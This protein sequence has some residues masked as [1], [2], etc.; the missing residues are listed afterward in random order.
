MPLLAVG[1]AGAVKREDLDTY[2]QLRRKEV[3]SRLQSALENHAPARVWLETLTMD[4][5]RERKQN[6]SSVFAGEPLGEAEAADA[7]QQLKPTNDAANLVEASETL[8][9]AFCGFGVMQPYGAVGIV[10]ALHFQFEVN[11]ERLLAADLAPPSTSDRAL[12]A[13]ARTLFDD[14]EAA[15]AEL[16]LRCV[17]DAGE[18][19]L[20]ANP[21][22]PGM[23]MG[24]LAKL[25]LFAQFVLVLNNAVEATWY[26]EA[27][28]RAARPCR[29]CPL[30]INVYASLLVDEAPVRQMTDGVEVVEVM[31]MTKG[32][33]R[34]PSVGKW[35]S[36][37]REKGFK[38]LLDDFEPRHPAVDSQ[39]DGVKTSVF[40]NAFH[41]QQAL[42]NAAQ[43]FPVGELAFSPDEKRPN[44]M[45]VFDYY[46]TILPKLMCGIDS[47][48][49]EG[50][51]NC[52]KSEV[53]PGP[54]LIFSEPNAT[55]ASAH[56][57]KTAALAMQKLSPSFTM[58]QQGGRAL[59]DGEDFDEDLQAIVAAT[60]RDSKAART[61]D[62]GT[63]AWTGDQA[64]ARFAK[65]SR[66][67]V[68]GI[69]VQ[70]KAAKRQ[71]VEH[72]PPVNQ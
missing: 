63:I 43:R 14:A 37:L 51:E 50:S 66:P 41:V 42:K 46:G 25:P 24:R 8:I 47:I 6:N 9:S 15:R 59:Y 28:D 12:V 7:L 58:F 5:L 64:I 53:S 22:S 69:I 2:L 68:C 16:L 33:R 11:T 57:Y 44:P 29:P 1:A 10:N 38:V 45:D 34:S 52:S 26:R 65:R 35:V 36:N 32:A 49:M 39:P 27:F 23:P 40:A 54:P 13:D 48:V 20:V 55:L 56:V 17:V 19:G 4:D 18:R 21:F 67:A 61:S 62:A 3:A 72:Q 60:A 70:E 71:R 30:A 31:E